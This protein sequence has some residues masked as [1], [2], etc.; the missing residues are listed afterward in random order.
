MRYAVYFVSKVG[1]NRRR[2]Y[3]GCGLGNPCEPFK[4]TFD[5]G[6]DPE[7]ESMCALWEEAATKFKNSLE[8]E[9]ANIYTLVNSS[10][11]GALEYFGQMDDPNPP[12]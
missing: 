2:H 1:R 11:T 9:R 5:I 10:E 3:A 4:G 12:H 6:Q 8:P 7:Y